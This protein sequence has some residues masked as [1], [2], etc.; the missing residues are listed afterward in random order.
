VKRFFESVTVSPAATGSEFEVHLDG[1]TVRTP[2]RNPLQLPGKTLAEAVSGEWDA[3]GDEIDVESMPFTRMAATAIDRVGTD[4]A[5]YTDQIAAYAET[6]LVCYRAPTP[7]GLVVMQSKSWQ[8]LVDWTA[9][10]YGAALQVTEGIAPVEQDP[11]A[12]KRIRAALD[13]HDAFELAAL[14]VATAACGSVV[15][16]L[17]LT[18]NYIDAQAAFEASQL[19]ESFQN[20]IWGVD[21]EAQQRR[22]ILQA[23]LQAT[24]VFLKLLR[25]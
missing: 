21:S 6:D 16:G 17:A 2:L 8:P 14:S 23:D 24:A 5:G 13:A 1:R 15:I 9:E 11:A 19:D 3:Q 4:R 10:T 7:S 18:G 20:A 25:S 12:L 22:D